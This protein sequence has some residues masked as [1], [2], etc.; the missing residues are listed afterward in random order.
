MNSTRTDFKMA[1]V[2]IAKLLG[3]WSST[4]HSSPWISQT[5]VNTE[6]QS[7]WVNGW[8]VKDFRFSR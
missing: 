6:D 4:E 5:S 2:Q 7:K 8:V 3:E 1:N